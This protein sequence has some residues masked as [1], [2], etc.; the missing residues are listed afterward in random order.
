MA[1]TG[2]YTI[3]GVEVPYITFGSV[4]VEEFGYS[5]KGSGNYQNI[6]NGLNA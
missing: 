6:L 3:E 5:G 1:G 2:T 4:G